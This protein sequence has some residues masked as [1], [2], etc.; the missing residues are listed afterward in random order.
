[1]DW[2]CC[3]VLSVCLSWYGQGTEDRSYLH[4]EQKEKGLRKRA[5]ASGEAKEGEGFERTDHDGGACRG[6]LQHEGNFQFQGIRLD[7]L[8]IPLAAPNPERGT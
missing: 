6:H 5:V 1:L 3:F 2:P 8:N 7:T 4:K